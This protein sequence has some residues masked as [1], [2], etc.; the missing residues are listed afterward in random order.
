VVKSELSV[1]ASPMSASVQARPLQTKVTVT[2][3]P[4]PKLTVWAPLTMKE[5][6]GSGTGESIACE[7]TYSNFRQFTVSTSVSIKKGG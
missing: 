1:K 4:V 2:Y 7:A 5:E 6:Y 3:A